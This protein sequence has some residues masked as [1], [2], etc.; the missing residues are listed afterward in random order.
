[1]AHTKATAAPA[2]AA[3]APAAAATPAAHEEP[4]TIVIVRYSYDFYD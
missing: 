2:P 1:M 4:A 3:P